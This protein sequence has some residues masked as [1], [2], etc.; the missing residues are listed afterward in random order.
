M[1]DAFMYRMGLHEKAAFPM[2][3]GCG[4]NIPAIIATRIMEFR[5]NRVITASLV[6]L[7]PWSGQSIVIS[8]LVRY[9]MGMNVASPYSRN[10]KKPR[11]SF[12]D[13][14]SIAHAKRMEI[15]NMATFD[16]DFK[17]LGGIHVIG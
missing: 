2:L 7:I 3:L 1:F 4:C 17:R 12:T 15:S 8:G 6:L 16:E 11:F 14:T 9:Y 13:C 5:C 10:K